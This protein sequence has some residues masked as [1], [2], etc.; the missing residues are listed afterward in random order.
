MPE[1]I[2]QAFVLGAG[3]G[4]RLKRLTAAR[5]KPL[6][7][8]ANRPLITFAFDHLIAAGI[9]RF[10]VNTHHCAEEY[11]RAFPGKIYR[12]KPLVF[13]HEP[14]LLETGGGIANVADLLGEKPFIVY[15]GDV[16]TD[17]PLQPAIER[18]F[19]SGN[20]VTLVLRSNCEPRHVTL[21]EATG[22]VLDIGARLHPSIAPGFLFT[23]IY[24][25]QPEFIRRIPRAEK[26]SVIPIFIEMIRA[27]ARI[28]GVVVDEG[29]WH[30]LGTREQYLAVNRLLHETGGA[31]FRSPDARIAAD[32]RL[33]GATAI[34]SGAQVGSGAYLRD[35][36]VW[37]NAEIAPGSSLDHC[38]ITAGRS[39]SGTHTGED[40]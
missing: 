25:V 38:I 13:R 32:A 17:L 35:C 3:L 23:G 14:V 40:F 7:S 24:L 22:R 15:N 36:I 33:C 18:H 6:I 11:D 26:I 12:E 30:D 1:T 9:S 21:D 31:H 39:V 5:P 4:T 19:Q 2:R 29:R 34:G 28:G 16:L 37:E 20:E 8:V 10:V 27:E